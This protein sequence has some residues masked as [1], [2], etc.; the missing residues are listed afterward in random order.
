MQKKCI[1]EDR[2]T[3]ELGCEESTKSRRS[4]GANRDEEHVTHN[5]CYFMTDYSL[6]T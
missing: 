6:D 2:K 3:I 5:D 4:K 1:L